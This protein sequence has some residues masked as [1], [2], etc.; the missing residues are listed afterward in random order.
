MAANFKGAH[1]PPAVIRTGVCWYGAYSLSMRHVEALM[2]ERGV[3][4]AC[5]HGGF[6]SAVL[7]RGFYRSAVYSGWVAAACEAV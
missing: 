6:L 3:K 5:L 7:A 4:D 2:L 1:F